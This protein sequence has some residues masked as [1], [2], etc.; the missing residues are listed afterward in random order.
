MLVFWLRYKSVIEL[1][2]V[3]QNPSDH[4]C[5][6]RPRFK[7]FQ[8]KELTTCGPSAQVLV[9]LQC[10]EGL[11]QQRIVP[12]QTLAIKP[13]EKP[14][15]LTI[16]ACCPS[17]PQEECTCISGMILQQVAA[18]TSIQWNEC[19]VE[20]ESAWIEASSG[21][22]TSGWTAGSTAGTMAT[23]SWYNPST[24]VTAAVPL[25][26]GLALT[27]KNE[28]EPRLEVELHPSWQYTN[29]IKW[30]YSQ[31][32]TQTAWCWCADCAVDLSGC[33]GKWNPFRSH[34][35]LTLSSYDNL[36]SFC[37]STAVSAVLGGSAA[38]V[39]RSCTISSRSISTK[40]MSVTAYFPRGQILPTF[41]YI[42]CI[43][44]PY[45]TQKLQ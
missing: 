23:S 12:A 26:I 19:S 36:R 18:S 8:C 38:T 45:F 10:W 1:P 31:Q 42:T 17:E 44:L 7:W 16:T 29:D 35:P 13:L 22:W 21:F 3:K 41:G 33:R 24:T 39:D 25:L 14:M 5:D 11:Q 9:S 32:E 20:L 4:I 2:W 34:L 6:W 43:M 40:C 15:S 37:S 27:V 28:T 30:L